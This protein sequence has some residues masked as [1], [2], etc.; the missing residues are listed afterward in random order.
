MSYTEH[1]KSE[2]PLISFCYSA[3]H[4]PVIPIDNVL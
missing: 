2:K 4:S 1:R 3:T